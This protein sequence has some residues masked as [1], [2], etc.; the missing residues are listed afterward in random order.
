[1]YEGGSWASCPVVILGPPPRGD[2][3]ALVSSGFA[4]PEMAQGAPV[5]CP[6]M[7]E[8]VP[9]KA[10]SRLKEAPR[11]P[12]DPRRQPNGLPRGDSE[13]RGQPVTKLRVINKRRRNN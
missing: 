11:H 13:T 1:M 4:P 3:R 12:R 10:P 5:A 8:E 2:S 6:K 9:E 7:A